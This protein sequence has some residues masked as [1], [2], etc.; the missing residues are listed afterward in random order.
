[1]YTPLKWV[2]GGMYSKVNLKA[3]PNPVMHSKP[4]FYRSDGSGRD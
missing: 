4:I 2:T 3:K 1:M